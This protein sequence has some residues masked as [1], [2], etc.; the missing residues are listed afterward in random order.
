[1]G[2]RSQCSTAA[3]QRTVD[4]AFIQSGRVQTSSRDQ[5]FAYSAAMSFRLIG[6]TL[7]AWPALPN[8]S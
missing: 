5:A 3:F 8:A 6:L 1:M 7:L 4:T 2:R